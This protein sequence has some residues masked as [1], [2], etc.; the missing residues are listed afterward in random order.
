M[1]IS[2]FLKEHDIDIPK[3]NETWL[4]SK[5]KPDI[6]NYV[7]T[8]ND[9]PRWGGGG[10]GIIVHNNIKFDIV[11]TFLSDDADNEA[12]TIILKDSQFSTTIS[13]IYIQAFIQA[14]MS[15]FEQ[16]LSF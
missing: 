7:I 6:P 14:L 16:R 15:V 13:T 11:D 9:R 1:E 5:F 2:L 3:L 4:K 12:P 8:H 10:K